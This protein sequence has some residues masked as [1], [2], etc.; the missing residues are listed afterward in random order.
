M[1]SGSRS[2]VALYRELPNM[3]EL[4]YSASSP[5]C[6][7]GNEVPKVVTLSEN[8]RKV[9][10]RTALTTVTTYGYYRKYL[11]GCANVNQFLLILRMNVNFCHETLVLQNL[12]MKETSKDEG[13]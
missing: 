7:T 1:S 9:Y 4:T 5:S 8:F 2:D 12:E 10:C 6:S 13:I 3:V 11:F